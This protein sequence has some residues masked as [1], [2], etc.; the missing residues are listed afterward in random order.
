MGAHGRIR[1][2]TIDLDA[3]IAPAKSIVATNGPDSKTVQSLQMS[4][5]AV[6]VCCVGNYLHATCG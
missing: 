3:V 6:G 2:D 5:G 1:A 4:T